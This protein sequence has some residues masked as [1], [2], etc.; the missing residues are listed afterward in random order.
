MKKEPL[1]S[2]YVRLEGF[3]FISRCCRKLG[4]R[5]S[6]EVGTARIEVLATVANRDPE[7]R[8]LVISR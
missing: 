8:D 3:F 5:Y 1:Q 2:T 7:V 6:G 4:L